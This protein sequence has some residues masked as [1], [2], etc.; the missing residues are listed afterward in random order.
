[1]EEWSDGR[2]VKIKHHTSNIGHLTFLGVLS[3]LK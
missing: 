2:K 1:M 3:E